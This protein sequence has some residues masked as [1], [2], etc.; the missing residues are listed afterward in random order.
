MNALPF[1]TLLAAFSTF[2]FSCTCGPS[3]T[4]LTVSPASAS[5]AIGAKV[6]VTATVTSG[7]LTAQEVS[8]SSSNPRIFTVA[9][10]P[11]ASAIITAIAPGTAT[12][13]AF[14]GNG[15]ATATIVVEK[16]KLVS[17][18]I[19]P[20]LATLAA[21]TTVSLKATGTYEDNTTQDVT[22]SAMWESA[23]VEVATVA[24]GVVSG[25]KVGNVVI[26]AS[27]GTISASAPVTVSGATLKSI[28]VT[29][30]AP[31]VPAGQTQA[32]V[33][34][35]TFSDNTTQD[36]TSMVTWRSSNA[37]VASVAPTGIAS[38]L[39]AG[40][41]VITATSG[42]LSATT[43][44]TVTNAVLVSIALTP[45]N[46]SLPVGRT[47]QFV[48]TGTFS[49]ATTQNLSAAVTW[50]SATTA[51]AT[52]SASGLATGVA[53]G[54]SVIKATSGSIS[55]SI[56]LT[57]TAATLVS[58]A[59]MPTNPSIPVGR[60][61]RFSAT[62]T[63]SD[64]STQDLTS[65]ATW[66]SAT[67]SVASIS[68]AAGSNGVATSAAVGTSIIKATSG[69]ISGSTTLT[70]TAATLVTIS[71]TPTN[72][73][74]PVGRSLRLTATGTFSDNSTQDLTTSVTWSSGTLAVASISNAAGSNG[75]AAALAVGTSFIKASSGA[76]SD[77]TT[78]TVTA[79]TLVSIAVSPTNPS[80]PVGRAL[81]L[82][83]TGTFSDNSTQ[84]L[85]ASVT[86][87]SA[88]ETVATVSNAATTQGLASAL[89]AGT[90]VISATSGAISS[91]VTLTVTN[92]T[93][94]SIGV[95]PS[96][97]SL[98]AGSTQQFVALG[99]FS[100]SSTQD[101][102]T[103]VTWAS[104]TETV[105]T[106][107]NAAASRGLASAVAAGT[108]LISATSGTISG[109]ST[110]TVRAA[111]LVSLAVTPSSSS[112]NV[113][114]TQ[115]FVATGTY[116]DS[117][118]Q[119][120]TTSVTWSSSP[121]NLAT[122]SNAAPTQ[123]LATGV[124]PGSVTITAT[125]GTITANAALTVGAAPIAPLVTVVTPADAATTV[126]PLTSIAVTFDTAMAPAS[127]TSQQSSGPCTGSLQ[128]SRDNFSSCLGIG[129]PVLSAGDTVATATPAPGLSFGT[130]YKI[131]V[132][133]AAQNASSTPLATDFV[134]ATGF[135]TA[136]DNRC[137]AG[138]VISQVF[139]A[140]G[141]TGAPYNA[142]YV[143]L[144]NPGLNAVNLGGLSIQYASVT[145]TTWSVGAL[146][147]VSVPAGG[148]FLVRMSATGATGAALTSDFALGTPIAMSGSNAKVALST[149][150][151]P[152]T[153]AC[154]S[155]AAVLDMF[156]YG[157]TASCS[158]GTPTAVLS[159]TL[160]AIRNN[161]GCTDNSNN[162]SDFTL[163][164]PAPRNGMTP[165]QVCSCAL[166]E[167]NSS[168]E[169]D[170]CNLQAPTSF[171]AIT[172]NTSPQI[173][174]RV[175][176]LGVTETPGPSSFIMQLGYGATSVNPQYQ[177]G[178]VWAPMT[179]GAQL[180]ND[181]EFSG[182]FVTPAPGLYSYTT[183]VSLDGTNWTYCD[184]DA[185][186][187]NAALSFDASKLG[188]ATVSLSP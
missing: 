66:S 36:I 78:L 119:V 29:P 174:G 112:V 104:A 75:L 175:F 136:T 159:A 86:W 101:L 171:A 32:L 148:Y 99:T 127:I 103:S 43:M 134:T 69:A 113:A 142:D 167:T 10:G 87:A 172:G 13:S 124:S 33:A 53:P 182:T 128:V 65:S 55:G 47:Q 157:P 170:F 153:G 56:T 188:S 71:V 161:G 21:G 135:T 54:S 40:G 102:T 143:E 139:G 100:D 160:A 106:I 72:P 146:P 6:T 8:W 76:I 178:Y 48:A 169:A 120:L 35:G 42:A 37:A 59:V 147:S 98:A 185:A 168:A 94:V 154:P 126:A 2:A 5:L 92:A 28:Q 164:A 38:A 62:G 109:S 180:G 122:I 131:K 91:A 151:T 184:V 95:T 23:G 41:S 51:S 149:G 145:G 52:I 60:T 80:I 166:N 158:K 116:S 96:M 138:L 111:T 17:L 125:S 50:N 61:Q 58:I 45:T 25:L 152:L 155:G 179:F 140:G 74:V 123:G 20:P 31:S 89:A 4:V 81:Q 70:V 14:L 57:V 24:A 82:T 49:D 165:A 144:H 22:S 133:T 44:L 19:T 129:A 183:R 110:L 156:G 130:V 73:S 132:T 181:E 121:P 68:N 3:D 1:R 16:A 7:D 107:S 39:K 97:P 141:N 15:K 114:G 163:A 187:S 85:T 173:F 67:M 9:V 64:N 18:A 137:A 27:V 186:G 177:T 83:A 30:T 84:D 79:A 12:L 77:S 26:K 93:L 11:S 34:T 150:V 117:S 162:S 105:A 108:S 115:Q 118:T 46:P 90:S 63:F 88:T 176:E